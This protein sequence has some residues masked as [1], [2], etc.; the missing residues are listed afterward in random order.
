MV[1]LS[2]QPCLKEDRER[3]EPH[4]GQALDRTKGTNPCAVH[5]RCSGVQELV[6]WF[7]CFKN[8]MMFVL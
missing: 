2:P 5:I 6:L 7:K 8:F 1:S 4:R 3:L